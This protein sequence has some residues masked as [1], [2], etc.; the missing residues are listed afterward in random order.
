[1]MFN[2]QYFSYL[3]ADMGPQVHY[4]TAQIFASIQHYDLFRKVCQDVFQDPYQYGPEDSQKWV[5][6]FLQILLWATSPPAKY[7]Y[8]LKVNNGNR[9]QLWDKHDPY[10]LLPHFTGVKVLM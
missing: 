8:G 2:Q 10:V 3:I 9:K 7:V 1:M 6:L 4:Q 5:F